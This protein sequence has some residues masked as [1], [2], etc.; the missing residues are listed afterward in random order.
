MI[1]LLP[2]RLDARGDPRLW[3]AVLDRVVARFD[4][5]PGALV[6]VGRC[7]HWLRPHQSRWLTPDGEFAWPTGYGSG[8]GGMSVIALPQFDWSV[9][10]TWATDRWLPAA[11]RSARPALRLAIP[12]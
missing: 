6:Q 2:D 10:L 12:S 1:E 5:T 3:E 9:V 4:W 11:D 8:Q 7:S